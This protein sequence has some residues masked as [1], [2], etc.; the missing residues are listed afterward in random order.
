MITLPFIRIRLSV[1]LRAG[2]GF[3]QNI[4]DKGSEMWDTQGCPSLWRSVGR[5]FPG[6]ETYGRGFRSVEYVGTSRNIER[7]C[8]PMNP[9]HYTAYRDDV[10]VLYVCYWLK[11]VAC[12]KAV[13]CDLSKWFWCRFCRDLCRSPVQLCVRPSD[14]S[15]AVQNLER[16]D[17]ECDRRAGSRTE[18]DP[19]SCAF[20]PVSQQF[21]IFLY[22]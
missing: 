9:V 17:G 16:H 5:S 19:F 1:G 14:I 2:V 18:I 12:Y 7:E 11:L 3:S 8:L 10:L 15:F 6:S 22:V 4:V 13:D 20:P 21:L